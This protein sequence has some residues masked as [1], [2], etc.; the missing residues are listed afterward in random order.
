MLIGN[1]QDVAFQ[2]LTYF[3][4]SDDKI[5]EVE[6]AYRKGELLTGELKKMAIALLHDYVKEFQE[7]RKGVSEQ[8]LKAYMTP[9]KLEWK[10]NPNPVPKPEKPKG[11]GKKEAP[12]EAAKPA[13]DANGAA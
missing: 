2:Y 7:N 8:K 12:K 11:G 9:R 1:A 6:A 13:T 4:E 5:A 10:G 3:E